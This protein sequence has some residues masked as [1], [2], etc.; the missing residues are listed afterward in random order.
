MSVTG[1]AHSLAQRRVGGAF[2]RRRPIIDFSLVMLICGPELNSDVK[3]ELADPEN[4]ILPLHCRFVGKFVRF[5]KIRIFG[6]FPEPIAGVVE[7]VGGWGIFS[8]FVY[9]LSPVVHQNQLE[10][11][12]R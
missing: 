6:Q 4:G 10:T 1:T 2:A 3:F 9:P 7:G 11:P 5:W 12:I 8:P